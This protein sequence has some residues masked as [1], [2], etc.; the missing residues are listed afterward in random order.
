MSAL[1]IRPFGPTA[2]DRL[3]RGFEGRLAF[4]LL[5][6][7]L[8]HGLLFELWPVMDAPAWDRPAPSRPDVVR[9]DNVTLPDEPP[10]VVPPATPV[11]AADAPPTATVEPIDWNDAGR[12]PP[13]PAD[14]A[15]TPAGEALPFTPYTTPPGLANPAEVE[16]ALVREYPPM[17]REA[18]I[19]GT[20]ALLVHIDETGAV[21]ETRVGTS[22]GVAGLDDAAL[23]VA[24]VMRF[25]PA[26]NRDQ[27]VPVWIRLPVAF[28]VR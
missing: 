18:G 28:R 16:R 21:L 8:L 11:V 22:S 12:L 5:A 4:S 13:P 9:I 2:N 1:A 15:R 7:T 6:A 26:L 17:L 24:G 27:A 3:K 10:R 19:G 23:R 14:V 20:V 25:R